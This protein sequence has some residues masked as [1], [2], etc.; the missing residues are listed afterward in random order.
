MKLD[1]SGAATVL[2]TMQGIAEAKLP[3]YFLGIMACA[4]NAVSDRALH[5]GDVVKTY[6]GKTVEVNNTDAEGRMVLCDALA[7]VEKN[8]KPDLMVDIATL[9]G[10]VT[11]ALGYHI[12]GLM[13][14]NQKAIDEYMDCSKVT[15]E[16]TWPFPLDDDFVKATKGKFSDLVNVTDGVRAGTIM[17]AAFLKNFVDDKTPWLHLDVA[18]SAWVERP[19]PTTKYGATAVSIRSLLELAERHSG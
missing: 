4:E 14:N 16:R 18:G 3:G 12:T 2:A 13:G 15:G 11:V 19:T 5:P 6:S 1:M 7:Y 8:Y 10:A 17:G 9:T